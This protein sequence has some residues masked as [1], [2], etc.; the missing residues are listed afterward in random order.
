MFLIASGMAACLART[1][2]KQF[3][4]TNNLTDPLKT[5]M[6]MVVG[7]VKDPSRITKEK[8]E[9]TVESMNK[10]TK[11]KLLKSMRHVEMKGKGQ[12]IPGKP[13]ECSE[14]RLHPTKNARNKNCHTFHAT[15]V[16][17]T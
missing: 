1:P 14:Q 10:E 5:G 15:K 13:N 2:T 8:M 7:H 4:E 9:S 11:V 3:I 6:K 17:H 16:R 12:I